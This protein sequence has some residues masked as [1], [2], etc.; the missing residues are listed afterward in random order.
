MKRTLFIVLILIMV[1]GVFAALWT[2]ARSA[3]FPRNPQRLIPLYQD[4]QEGWQV[5]AIGNIE[6][7]PGVGSRQIIELC[8]G[9][10]W[11]IRT[12]CL[13]PGQPVPQLGAFCSQTSP[14][15]FW[16]GAGVQMLQRL[17]ILQTPGIENTRTPTRTATR[18]PQATATLVRTATSAQTITRT[19]FP[20]IE[21]TPTPTRRAFITATAYYRPRAGGPGNL[22]VGGVLLASIALL[23]L[24]GWWFWR[25]IASLTA[26]GG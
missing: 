8:H 1:G 9:S 18:R 25:K 23:G 12:Y 26:R 13:D 15:V 5:C 21:E 6:N 4:Q 2:P 20:Q 11:R 24:G 7:I 22:E 3:F 19:A 10:G 14:G 17:S 16:C